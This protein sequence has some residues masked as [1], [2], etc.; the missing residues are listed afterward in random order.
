MS[1]SALSW[2]CSK[3]SSSVSGPPSPR[4]ESPPHSEWERGIWRR[5]HR[6]SHRQ[7][8]GP[9]VRNRPWRWRGGWA[10]GRELPQGDCCHGDGC[11]QTD[12]AEESAKI[13]QGVFGQ[14]AGQRKERVLLWWCHNLSVWSGTS[15]LFY[16]RCN[17]DFD[18]MSLCFFATG[19]SNQWA[20]QFS[21]Y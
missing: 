18:L 6:K 16:S 14:G 3:I 8:K 10:G 5:L 9:V 13:T 7:T 4:P 17:S 15:C 1:N 2:S 21:S 19:N 12:W 11:G 20:E